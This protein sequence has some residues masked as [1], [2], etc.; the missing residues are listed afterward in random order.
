LKPRRHV[1]KLAAIRQSLLFI[2]I[3]IIIIII[4]Q[5][6]LLSFGAY[7]VSMKRC[8]THSSFLVLLT[9]GWTPW[10]G[11]QLI[12]WPLPTHDNTNAV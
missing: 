1:K 10:T 9:V 6:I 12:A 7:K 8:F 3:I 2:V 5:F 11:D 4:I